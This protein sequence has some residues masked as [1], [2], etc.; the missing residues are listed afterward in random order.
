MSFF[1]PKSVLEPLYWKKIKIWIKKYFYIPQMLSTLPL[2][3]HMHHS[4]PNLSCY[5]SGLLKWG[6]NKNLKSLTLWRFGIIVINAWIL[7]WIASW[8]VFLRCLILNA[9]LAGMC[10][11]IIAIST[12]I[13]TSK[14]SITGGT[15]LAYS[16]FIVRSF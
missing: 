16:V 7:I 2:I 12:L 9:I 5:L 11:W 6:I 10:N 8:F 4:Y 3:F 14:S 13:I 1:Y 15:I